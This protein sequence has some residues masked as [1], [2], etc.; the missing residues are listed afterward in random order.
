[1][2][3]VSA[4]ETDLYQSLNVNRDVTGCWSRNLSVGIVAHYDL[5]F[6]A[7]SVEIID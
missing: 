5:A 7:F 4:M 2:A 1:M 6:S 3:D